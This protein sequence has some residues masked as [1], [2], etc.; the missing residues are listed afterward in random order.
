MT[1]VVVFLVA[2]SED[3]VTGCGLSAPVLVPL[4]GCMCMV[5]YHVCAHLNYIIWVW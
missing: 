1:V 4:Y 5:M 3:F 2:K